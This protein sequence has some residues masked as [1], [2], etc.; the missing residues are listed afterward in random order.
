MIS[1]ITMILLLLVTTT[2]SMCDSVCEHMIL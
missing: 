2:S 1:L